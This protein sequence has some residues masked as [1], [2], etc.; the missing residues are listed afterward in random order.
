MGISWIAKKSLIKTCKE[1]LGTH[2]VLEKCWCLTVS[3]SLAVA[4]RIVLQKHG[5]GENVN[6]DLRAKLSVNQFPAVRDLTGVIS[7]PPHKPIQVHER[8]HYWLLGVNLS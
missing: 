4:E 5:F 6:L 2:K 7:K 8:V 1:S 3:V